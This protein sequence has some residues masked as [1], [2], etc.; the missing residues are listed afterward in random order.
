MRLGRILATIA[1]LWVSSTL[2]MAARAE[3]P[4][5]ASVQYALE[6]LTSGIATASVYS[7]TE[8]KITP[9]RTWKSVSGHYCR[10]YRITVLEPASNPN[11][12]EKTRCRDTD[13][14]WRQI[15]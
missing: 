7:G 6:N 8:V 5:E 9:V 13:G 14:T 3:T 2:A 12:A 4:Y 15:N 1:A 10:E 11:H